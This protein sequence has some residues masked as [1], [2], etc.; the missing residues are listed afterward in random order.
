MF[1]KMR[2]FQKVATGV[3]LTF[4]GL[5]V[6]VTITA[7]SRRSGSTRQDMV[8]AQFLRQEAMKRQSTA[9]AE[10]EITQR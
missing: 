7:Y 9:Q 1:A 5:M 6:F 3:L 2:L 8:Q 4:L 10:P